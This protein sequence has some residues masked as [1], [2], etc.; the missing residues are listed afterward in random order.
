MILSQ[1]LPFLVPETPSHPK[2]QSN[3]PL[4][5]ITLDISR[6]ERIDGQRVKKITMLANNP[7]SE[8]FRH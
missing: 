5:K 7:S 8:L 3:T 6:D 1:L 2:L 4:L